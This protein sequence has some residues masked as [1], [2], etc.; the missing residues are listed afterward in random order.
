MLI[1][2][3]GMLEEEV[4]GLVLSAISSDL[5]WLVVPCARIPIRI[6]FDSKDRESIL[7]DRQLY[8]NSLSLPDLKNKK[9]ILD[10]NTLILKKKI[11]YRVDSIPG[12]WD[13]MINW[14]YTALYDNEIPVNEIAQVKLFQTQLAMCMED[15]LDK[16]GILKQH[17]IMPSVRVDTSMQNPNSYGHSSLTMI[18]DIEISLTQM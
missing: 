18:V 7:T 9:S 15:I 14:W 10:T 5:K 12:A 16:D 17:K 6:K 1:K 11:E 3:D 4:L 2:K 13:A 8:I